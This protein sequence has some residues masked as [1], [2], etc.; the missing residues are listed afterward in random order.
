[1]QDTHNF[2]RKGPRGARARA[3]YPPRY[4]YGLLQRFRQLR[5]QREERESRGEP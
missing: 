5:D 3:R 1:M 4:L 2:I